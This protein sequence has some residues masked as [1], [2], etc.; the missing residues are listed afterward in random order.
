MTDNFGYYQILGVDQNATPEEIKR[1]Y[2]QLAKKYHPDVCHQPDCIRKFREVNEAYEFLKDNKQRTIYN[3]NYNN[4]SEFSQDET[5]SN[6]LD[7]IILNLINSLGNPNSIMRNYAVE[8]LVRIGA[9]AFDPVI[10]ATSSM[11]EVVRRKTCDILGR[12]GNPQGIPVLIRLLND[13]DRY[14]RRRAAKALIQVNDQSAVAPLMN[15]LTD[16]EKK[17]RYRSAQALGVIRDRRAVTSLIKSLNDYSST[18][19]RKA[20]VAL[21]EIGDEQA[22][23]PITWCLK[24]PSSHVRN[25][26][27][28]TLKYK[29]NFKKRP[30][31]NQ[32]TRDNPRAR[33]IPDICPNCSNT[34]IPNT[35]YCPTC[36]FPLNRKIEICP[37]CGNPLLPSTNFC[38][39]CGAPIK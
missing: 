37:K 16:P 31:V 12:M 28:N 25:T 21:G 10:K 7:Q 29:F 5:Y 20:I 36:G 26:A 2:R 27:R 14:V 9:P 11:D 34:V 38:T 18:V 13:T 23:T 35:N 33:R 19:R 22:I 1:A 30:V 24:D 15:A 32:R 39:N 17:V 6:S 8:V 3:T 4:W